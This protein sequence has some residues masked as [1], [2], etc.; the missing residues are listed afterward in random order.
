MSAIIEKAALIRKGDR[1]REER[2]K[3]FTF[4]TQTVSAKILPLAPLS[5]ST[6]PADSMDLSW[7]PNKFNAW[8]ND[9][10]I[11][12][13]T[14][15]EKRGDDGELWGA[16]FNVGVLF[17]D[18][19]LDLDIDSA[20]P[21][22]HAALKHY[23][24]KD[25]TPFVW[26]RKSKP[27]SH[28][29][30]VLPEAFDRKKYAMAI[31]AL[32]D[33]PDMRIE[34][35][36]GAPT[37]NFFSAMP[38]T[39]HDSG[40]LVCWG[41]DYDPE[42]TVA[43]TSDTTDLLWLVRRAV[44]AALL[45]PHAIEG[46]RHGFFLALAG[47]LVRLYKQA[48]DADYVE[49]AMDAEAAY[50]F[51]LLVQTL[52]GDV[53]DR[54]ESFNSSW[55]KFMDDPTIPIKGS[56]ALAECMGPTGQKIRNCVL[57]LLVDDEGFEAAEAA[58]ERFV[59]LEDTGEYIDL[60]MLSP[61]NHLSPALN[62]RTLNARYTRYKVPFGEKPVPLPAFLKH[63]TQVLQAKG[64]KFDPDKEKTFVIK[65]TQEEFGV[66]RED[67]YVNMWCGLAFQPSDAPQTDRDVEPFLDL[68][69]NVIANQ[70]DERMEWAMSWF[71]DLF[72]DP[73]DKPGTALIL[74]G[75]QGSGKTLLGEI[76]G[77]VIGDA[78]YV[79][80][81]S[82]EDLTKEFNTRV[83]YRLFVQA[84]ETA[85]TQKTAL[86]R[87]LKEIVTGRQMGFVPKGKEARYAENPARYF[88]TSNQSGDALRVE[89]GHERRYTIFEVAP[90][91]VGKAGHWDK[92]A[93][94]SGQTLGSSK[95]NLRRILRYLMDYKY[96][97]A[98]LRL[99]LGTEEKILHQMN[100]LP[101]EAQ[102]LIDRLAAGHI[103]S[104][105]NHMYGYQAFKAEKIIKN[106]KPFITPAPNV[107]DR[108]EWPNV[109]DLAS[110]GV[111]YT[112]WARASGIRGVHGGNALVKLLTQLN[113]EP[114]S[115]HTITVK[116]DG[117]PNRLAVRGMPDRD[118]LVTGLGR[119]Y[120]ALKPKIV[121]MTAMAEEHTT[122]A[123]EEGEF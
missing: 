32:A 20:H 112:D 48:Q 11:S 55:R 116:R 68:M 42:R 54:K 56:S 7:H 121:E 110:L 78:H 57:R 70:D 47:T 1:F 6:L 5:K 84:D 120:P 119:L 75:A 77:S 52:A 61:H 81:G 117:I 108:T 9:Y 2:A 15:E 28:M 103:L 41:E 98:K 65:R 93:E 102:F 39:I 104:P 30:Y 122:D 19:L 66:E 114:L 101:P 40:E 8:N 94:W 50:E 16:Q 46:S 10:V 18:Q 14:D 60:E 22:L 95:L 37:S 25:P 44:A 63:S 105:E 64:T 86:A 74:T 79:K 24:A 31:R 69:Y 13:L 53:E 82:I 21:M 113:G 87:D 109:I 92:F 89:A 88:F 29:C 62:E 100:S 23:L 26:G 97:K 34:L 90:R 106:G 80:I 67:L 72:Q 123:E 58:L 85:S 4:A 76:I 17:C 27:V 43:P 49:Y 45:A 91:Y 111:D 12:V 59:Q 36:G 107:A 96:D 35:R 33:A 73:A 83:Q 3:T 38:G 71:A 51:F 118:K 99:A 115:R